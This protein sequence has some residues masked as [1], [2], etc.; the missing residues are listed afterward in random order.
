MNG[1]YSY[2][3]GAF[4]N[5]RKIRLVVSDSAPYPTT[6]T[7]KSLVRPLQ[8]RLLPCLPFTID[9]HSI[10]TNTHAI[11]NHVS[12]D[13]PPKRNHKYQHPEIIEK[14][15]LYHGK[16]ASNT[17]REGKY[18]NREKEGEEEK[19]KEAYHHWKRNIAGKERRMEQRNLKT[20]QFGC[21][22]RCD[23][24]ETELFMCYTSCKD[25]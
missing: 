13:M 12:P 2:F 21:R 9:W 10:E 16:E 11:G 4:R 17:M 18:I 6:R 14:A 8:L 25:G 24:D 3:G 20:A 22:K 15:G 7:D 23:R 19:G 5:G 1:K